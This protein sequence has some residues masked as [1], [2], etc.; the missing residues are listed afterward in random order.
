MP[1]P[2][3][4]ISGHPFEQ[5]I[6]SIARAGITNG[7]PDGTFRPG[8]PI[9]RGAM[10]AFMHRGFGRVGFSEASST[11]P[12]DGV[13]TAGATVQMVAV[14]NDESTSGFALVEATAEMRDTETNCPCRIELEIVNTNNGAVSAT[15][16]SMS[17]NVAFSGTNVQMVSVQERFVIEG[18]QAAN[19][20]ARFRVSTVGG[21]NSAIVVASDISGLYVPFNQYGTWGT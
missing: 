1:A 13:N 6:T 18:D 20:Q 14:S 19:F 7:Y 17:D 16:T 11:A 8:Q 4:D 2:F 5:Q 15:R 3:T 21:N 12:A 10:A 9:S